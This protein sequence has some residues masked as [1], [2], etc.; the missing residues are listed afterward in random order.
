MKKECHLIGTLQTALI[1]FLVF[2]YRIG[3]VAIDDYFTVIDSTFSPM[4]LSASLGK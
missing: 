2:F 1:L 4:L 3:R